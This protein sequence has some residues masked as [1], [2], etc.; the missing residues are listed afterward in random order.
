MTNTSRLAQNLYSSSAKCVFELLQN[1]DDNHYTNSARG[2]PSVAFSVYPDRIRAS[3]NED[4]F[5]AA[6]VKAICSVGQSSKKG[7]GDGVGYTGEKGI[8]FKSVFMAA[9]EVHIQSG[10]YSFRF[11]YAKGDSGLGM[12]TPIWTEH[13]EQLD[14]QRSHI[15]LTLRRDGGPGDAERRQAIIREQFQTI[16]DSILLFM[17][18]L[19][20][21]NVSFYDAEDV[22]ISVISF[23]VERQMD[24]AMVIK[25]T[26]TFDEDGNEE[27]TEIVK[28]YFM[29]KHVVHNLAPN[30]NRKDL[31]GDEHF[32]PTSSSNGVVILGFP[33]DAKSVPVLQNEYIFAFLPVKQMGFKVRLALPK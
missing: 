28:H 15:L 17:R 2:P 23:S 21:I 22:L 30:E 25:R 29:I 10:D 24:R 14:T 19:E 11:H 7:G 12:T 6:N 3:C 33:M 31:D 8:G 26:T 1:Y 18:K 4:G 20:Q 32:Q 9:E 27:V 13:D 16:H 5:T